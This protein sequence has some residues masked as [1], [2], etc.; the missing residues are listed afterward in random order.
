MT[1]IISQPLPHFCAP[2]PFELREHAEAM[3][4]SAF[5]DTYSP[6]GPVRLESWESDDRSARLGAQP[7]RF[8]AT[9]AIGGRTTRI[10]TVS[11]QPRS[12]RPPTTSSA[13]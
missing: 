1:A 5:T 10:A 7:R 3:S 11:R 12:A 9:L 6:S 13:T 4:W 2:L 8:T